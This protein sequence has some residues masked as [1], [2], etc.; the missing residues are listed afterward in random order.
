MNV[1]K[2]QKIK[3]SSKTSNKSLSNTKKVFK[4]VGLDS[5]SVSK[6]NI[7]VSIVNAIGQF[8][9]SIQTEAKRKISILD[10]S[11]SEKISSTSSSFEDQNDPF[12]EADCGKQLAKR[13]QDASKETSKQANL[14]ENL[15]NNI[16]K[17][18]VKK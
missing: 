12:Y 7:D 3:T 15:L 1:K 14:V 10:K 18:R 2:T 16:A 9:C 17:Q 11:Y 13:S 5:T 8:G 4:N 6:D